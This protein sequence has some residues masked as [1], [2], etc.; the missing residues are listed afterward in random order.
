MRDY[1]LSPLDRGWREARTIGV[2]YDLQP[3]DVDD[4]RERYVAF[5]RRH[6]RNKLACRLDATRTR[7]YP[8]DP[9]DREAHAMDVIVADDAD[10]RDG[11]VSWLSDR[12]LPRHSPLPVVIRVGPRWL[13]IDMAHLVGDGL[14]FSTTYTAFATGE[15]ERYGT[16][17]PMAG[18]GVVARATMRELRGHLGDW[19]RIAATP[20]PEPVPAG[21]A[22]VQPAPHI[23]GIASTLEKEQVAQFHQWRKSEMKGLTVTSLMTAAIARAMAAEG[24]KIDPGR[25]TSLFDIRRQL[26][27]DVMWQGN[28]TKAIVLTADP[29]DP[30]SVQE[31]LVDAAGSARALPAIL[32][33][34]IGRGARIAAPRPL[35]HV[36]DLPVLSVSSMPRLP[37]SEH[38]PWIDPESF[39][40]IAFSY[41]HTSTAVN[42][43]P[44]T[45]GGYLQCQASIDAYSLDP[46]ATQRA[47]D[48]LVDIP[49]LF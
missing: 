6:P 28:L 25:V 37:G 1:S 5:M 48:R 33:G 45:I 21:S 43:F 10:P 18:L 29:T 4:L 46:V 3:I 26:S 13:G 16:L 38:F 27:P 23:V 8:V 17:E 7:W 36:R 31:A 24:L 15:F 12:L 49:A 20:A 34:S 30:H 44:A 42:T 32:Q 2:V 9:A 22:A 19:R 47:F 39:Q 35:A 41:D 11:A 14:T 40:F